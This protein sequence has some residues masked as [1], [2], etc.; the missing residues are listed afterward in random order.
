MDYYNDEYLCPC[1]ENPGRNG[2]LCEQCEKELLLKLDN[3]FYDD[4]IAYLKEVYYLKP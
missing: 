2:M 4:E 1:G 3:L